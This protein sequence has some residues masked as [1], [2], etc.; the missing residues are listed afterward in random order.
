MSNPQD[1]IIGNQ[2]PTQTFIVTTPYI[3]IGNVPVPNNL[4]PTGPS[5]P[6]GPTGYFGP[7]GYTGPAGYVG[8]SGYTGPTGYTGPIG[9]TG[10]ISDTGDTGPTGNH[11][12]QYL[13]M[14]TTTL[15]I[16]AIYS[17]ISL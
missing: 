6:I 17:T 16:P 11:G 9:Y 5:G 10:S 1:I 2:G 4:G 8:P 14:S 7:T 3:Q 15:P 12:D 13:S